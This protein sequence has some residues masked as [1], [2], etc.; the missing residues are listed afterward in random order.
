M[1]KPHHRGSGNFW[2]LGLAFILAISILI[3]GISWG[4]DIEPVIATIKVQGNRRIEESA[5][6]FVLE[7]KV[8]EAY[9]PVRLSKD[10]HKI[11]DLGY[12]KDVKV[13]VSEGPS[14]VTL[15]YQVVERPTVEKIVIMGNEKIKTAD[16]E[17]KLGL[18]LHSVLDQ[19]AVQE[20]IQNLKSHYREQ[21][22]YFAEVESTLK[23]LV[24]NQVGLELRIK[25][26]DKLKIAKIQ[27]QGNR[28]FPEQK[29]KG[30]IQ[31]KEKGMISSILGKDLY[32]DVLVRD[33]MMRLQIFYQDNGFIDI[34][35]GEP[36]LQI[37][38]E[39]QKVSMTIPLKEGPQYKIGKVTVKGDEVYTQDELS[40]E[41]K[42]YKGTTFSRSLLREDMQHLSELYGQRGFAFANV[43]PL[44]EVNE[45][46]RKIDINFEIDKG[47]KIYVG[48]ISIQGNTKTKDK[49]VR[50]ELP[51]KEGELYNSEYL[52]NSEERLKQT[53]Y[54]EEVKVETQRRPGENGLVDLEVKLTEKPTGNITFGGGFSTSASILGQVGVEQNNLFGTGLKANLNGQ[55]GGRRSRVV[56]GVTQPYFMDLPIS[57]GLSLYDRFSEFPSFETNRM[58]SEANVGKHLFELVNAN[59]GLKLENVGLDQIDKYEIPKIKIGSNGIADLKRTIDKKTEEEHFFQKH[60]SR[61]IL[62]KDQDKNSSTSSMTASL[63]RSTLDNF[64]FPNQGSRI[65]LSGELAGGLGSNSF[66]KGELEMSQFIPLAFMYPIFPSSLWQKL[67]LRLRGNFGMGGGLGNT[68]FG[69]GKKND[70]LPLYER[71][72]L[73]GDNN[74]RGYDFE[75]VG[76]K[77]RI[78]RFHCADLEKTS[79]GLKKGKDNPCRQYNLIPEIISGDAIGGDY[80]ALLG[81]EVYFPIPLTL[82][83]V[84]AM[85]GLGFF[86]MGDVF[87]KGDAKDFF[88]IFSYRKSMGVG[89]RVLTPMGPVRA[90]VAYRLDEGKK[91]DDQDQE[92]KGGRIKFHFGFGNSF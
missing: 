85:R 82:P 57:A 30:V 86:D 75:D 29:L 69:L 88:N 74:L 24:G 44:T 34:Q 42:C 92:G 89:A 52:K 4:D 22:F 20:G 37:N 15:T 19:Q 17:E 61:S 7:S 67:T 5:I 54:F 43:E 41:L 33:D 87:A 12:F 51:L 18:K 21:G 11:Y 80:S 90:D 64:I 81:A 36:I 66:Y 35:V 49:V 70:G 72:F 46:S 13:D 3:E 79:E 9:S 71:F 83:Y 84:K 6:K 91:R 38:K 58:G 2:C 59:L 8:G 78:E 39:A 68:G 31:T 55:L 47:Q 60:T 77:V 73:G 10:I 25:E 28:V 40:N 48:Q 53:G 76:P 32:R 65:N 26:G 45:A 63:S 1:G 56:L 16:L 62:P 23:E 50:R 14:G 27:F